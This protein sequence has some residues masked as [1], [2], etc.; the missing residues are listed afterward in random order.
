MNCSRSI[1]FRHSTCGAFKPV[2][3]SNQTSQRSVI[4][5]N[6]EKECYRLL[7]GNRGEAL[8]NSLSLPAARLK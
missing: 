1:N 8:I 3:K 6:V 2:T 4:E 7:S 5:R